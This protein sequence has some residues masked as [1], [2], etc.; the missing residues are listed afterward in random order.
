M[1]L[2]CGSINQKKIGKIPHTQAYVHVHVHLHVHT[3]NVHMHAHA[4]SSTHYTVCSPLKDWS[5]VFMFLRHYTHIHT[6]QMSPI[7]WNKFREKLF[8][9][10]ED[11]LLIHWVSLDSYCQGP[12]RPPTRTRS[13]PTEECCA[14]FK[15]PATLF[16]EPHR[17]FSENKAQMKTHALVLY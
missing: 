15:G 5:C 7:R 16:P 1:K 14:L 11:I 13:V 12:E 9:V 4:H 2:S 10:S 17:G 3:H 6:H 8:L